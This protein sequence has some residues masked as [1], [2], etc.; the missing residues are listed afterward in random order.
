M[1]KPLFAI[2]FLLQLSFSYGQSG[3]FR[4]FI[5]SKFVLLDSAGGDLDRDGVRDLILILRDTAEHTNPDD[6]ARP[7]LLLKGDGKGSY[8]LA[9]RNDSVVLCAGCGGVM[10]DPY[11]QMVI[12]AGY[13]SIEF[14]GGSRERWTRIITF[15][16]DLVRKLFVLHRDAG[17]SYDNTAPSKTMKGYVTRQ[18]DFDKLPFDK[19][20]CYN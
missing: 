17:E 15:K 11:Q 2:A 5:P 20:R 6:A 12:K 3:S 9:G 18:Q 16:Y 8:Q 4:S 14:Y 1:K 10:G 19:F 7:L 13:F